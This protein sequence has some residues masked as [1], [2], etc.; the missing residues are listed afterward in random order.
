MAPTSSVSQAKTF[1]SAAQL[2]APPPVERGAA[3]KAPPI[4]FDQLKDQA[5]VV[6][7]DVV[8]FAKGVTEEQRK[9]VCNAMLLAQ[10]V[11]KRHVPSPDSETGVK[12]WYAAYFDT[13]S[14][15][16]FAV[17]DH[18]FTQY[19]KK[20][21][22]FE[23]HEA[24]LEVATALLAGAP[25]A[26]ALVNLT[27][28]ALH[29]M[30]EDSPWITLF[31]RESQSANTA[32]FQVSAV[33]RDG[34]SGFF[35]SILA[36]GLEARTALTQVLFFKFHS[37]EVKLFHQGGRVSINEEVLASV[38]QPIAGKLTAFAS[39]FIRMLP[40]D[41]AAPTTSTETGSGNQG[42]GNQGGGSQG[43]GPGWGAPSRTLVDRNFSIIVPPGSGGEYDY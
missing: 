11:A 33:E 34:N 21:Q 1:V 37:D 5:T 42:G 41:L 8:S 20:G 28:N 6:G 36:F 24:I 13:L 43:G 30:S 17:Q 3:A 9:D 22:S 16:G 27:L 31:D 38:R 14:N 39:D 32:R 4:D 40:D 2:P 26:L 29:K 7:S 35:V 10:L 12:A 18:G 19:Q 15:I 23:V 25:G